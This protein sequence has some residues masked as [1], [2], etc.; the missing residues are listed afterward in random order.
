MN[1]MTFRSHKLPYIY[2]SR[3]QIAL[4]SVINFNNRT[5][6]LLV[7]RPSHAALSYVLQNTIQGFS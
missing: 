7:K 4:A 5:W 2:K 6:T 3:S 1:Y